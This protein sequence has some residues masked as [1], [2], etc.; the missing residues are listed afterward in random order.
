MRLTLVMM[1]NVASLRGMQRN[2]V[3]V[4]GRVKSVTIEINAANTGLWSGEVSYYRVQTIRQ[5]GKQYMDVI[6]LTR[7]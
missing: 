2:Y 7:C 1:I 4:F 6:Y 5:T 3:G